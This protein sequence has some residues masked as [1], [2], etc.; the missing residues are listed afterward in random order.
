[1]T[2]KE[3]KQL[4]DQLIKEDVNGNKDL[5]NFYQNKVQKESQKAFNKAF[6]KAF[7]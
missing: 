5:I 7:K 6:E 2:I 3:I 4:I 1:M